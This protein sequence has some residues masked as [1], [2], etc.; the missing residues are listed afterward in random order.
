MF[1]AI[2][3]EFT[4][5]KVSKYGIISGPHFLVFGL[6]TEIYEV[7]LRIQPEY[8][9]TRTRNN[10]VFGHFSSSDSFINSFK[11]WT[12]TRGKKTAIFYPHI[13]YYTL[14]QNIRVV[15][16]SISKKKKWR[17]YSVWKVHQHIFM[18]MFFV[19]LYAIS[20]EGCMVPSQKN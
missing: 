18:I 19:C 14:L 12:R 11:R 20:R 7:N 9:K 13:L 1:W 16:N 17:W 3:E 15:K 2:L 5:W 4:A 8:R 10:S 6:N